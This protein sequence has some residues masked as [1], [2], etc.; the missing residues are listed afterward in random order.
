MWHGFWP[1]AKGGHPLR[2]RQHAENPNPCRPVDRRS[3]R[4]DQTLAQ[5][6][7]LPD[8]YATLVAG[9]KQW[10]TQAEQAEM[11]AGNIPKSRK[12]L[13]ANR[14]YAPLELKK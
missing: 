1:V 5:G 3:K 8:R 6:G 12:K 11:G 7:V 2:S 10:N 13:P 14:L 4:F 9:P